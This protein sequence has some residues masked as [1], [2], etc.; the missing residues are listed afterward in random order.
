MHNIYIRNSFNKIASSGLFHILTIFKI[1]INT[2][3]YALI[4]FSTR[5]IWI[6]HALKYWKRTSF[7]LFNSLCIYMYNFHIE[8]IQL[9]ACNHAS[10]GYNK[11]RMNQTRKL[12]TREHIDRRVINTQ[13]ENMLDK[14]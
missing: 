5:N 2:C 6:F 1:F 3:I 12:F 10:M 7:E 4:T 9:S 14:S 13:E 11:R 8:Y